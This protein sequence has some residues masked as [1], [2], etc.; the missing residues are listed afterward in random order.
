[1]ITDMTRSAQSLLRPCLAATLL[2]VGLASLDAQA[3]L[4][5]QDRES[6]SSSKPELILQKGH[7]G[8]INSMA[9]SPDGKFIVTAGNDSAVKIWDASTGLEL[10]SLPGN[11]KQA[12]AVAF[13]SDGKLVATG[14]EDWKLRVWEFET[15]RQ[16]R[17]IDVGTAITALAFSADGRWLVTGDIDGALKLCDVE[18]DYAS[19]DL[20]GY[21]NHDH[22]FSGR[23]T[24]TTFSPDSRF[25]AAVGSDKTA[26][27]WD[28]ASGKL[29]HTFTGANDSVDGISFSRE[30]RRLAFGSGNEKIQIWNIHER[31]QLIKEID[32]DEG[33]VS[34]VVF[35]P[36]GKFLVSTGIYGHVWDA[37]D[38]HQVRIFEAD[39]LSCLA[40][41][42][43]GRLFATANLH[44]PRVWDTDT[45]LEF[46]SPKVHA[47]QVD[48]IAQTFDGKWIAIQ[49]YHQ[50]LLWN[51]S[52]NRDF[53][54]RFFGFSPSFDLNGSSL[55]FAMYSST[56]PGL[57]I[58]DMQKQKTL[59]RI[60][61]P[62]PVAVT[63]SPDGSSIAYLNEG[64]SLQIL[65][66]V[67]GKQRLTLKGPGAF[68]LPAFSP[69]GQWVAYNEEND[70]VAVKN[71]NSGQ[72]FVLRRD[73]ETTN[74]PHFAFS[75]DGRLLAFPT[76]HGVGFWDFAVSGAFR[77]VPHPEIMG[78]SAIRFSPDGK[79]VAISRYND[80]NVGTIDILNVEAGKEISAL[81]YSST[82][83]ADVLFTP[84]ES[85]LLTA[86]YDGVVR[87]WD[88]HSGKMQA[89]L[90]IL[91][92]PSNRDE[93]DIADWAVVDADGRFDGSPGGLAAF[94]WVVGDETL[95]LDQLKDRYYEPGLLTKILGFNK[96]P[97]RDVAAFK[98][99]RLF[100]DVRFRAP[101]PGSMQL[102]LTLKNRGGGIGPV[103]VLVNGK[104]AATDARG[105]SVN[106]N[107]SEANLTVDLSG[108]DY[109]PGQ[110]NE[111]RVVARNQEGYLASRGFT[112]TW[113][114]EGTRNDSPPELWAIVGGI[115]TYASPDVKLRYAAKDAADMAHALRLAGQK[116]FGVDKVHLMLLTTENSPGALPPVKENFEKAFEEARHA[117]PQDVLLVYLAGHGVALNSPALPG[118]S[119]SG[120]TDLYA[121]L[122]ADARSANLSDL[123]DPALRAQ[124]TITSDELTD[125]IK[126]IPALKQVMILDT[127]DAGAAATKLV[128][129]RD[130]PADQVRALDRLKDRTGFHVLM[131]AAADKPSYEASE[132][133]QGLLT[134]ALLLGMRG[135]SLRNGEFMDVSQ[136]FQ[137]ATDE[138]PEL[139]KNI[140]GIQKPIVAAPSG[141]SFDVGEV[142]DSVKASIHL[143][144]AKPFLLRPLLLD[145]DQLDDELRLSAALRKRLDDESYAVAGG[146]D[147]PL[148]AVFLDTDEFPGAIRVNGSYRVQGSAVAITVALRRDDQKF[149]QLQVQGTKENI[150]DMIERLVNQIEGA[151]S[152][153]PSTPR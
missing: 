125:W 48:K 7:S 21:L 145:A 51:W 23:V 44:H 114:P 13:S 153:L 131:G 45:M 99:V 47:S 80:E 33:A 98:D 43:D 103:Q 26:R 135:A 82:S 93:L 96:E 139:S 90:A 132:Y 10:R 67:T 81:Q 148:S 31:Y 88:L 133:D 122:T 141:T 4:K 150:P 79:L 60:S 64:P 58:W 3:P 66:A 115:S 138:V 116:L 5:D 35:S 22:A 63:L 102:K 106:P 97:V 8:V 130:I 83:A 118:A 84:D 36:D 109:V 136:W 87:I 120:A 117:K 40:F 100:P 101:T 59:R 85:H 65:D 92:T 142:D 107:A 73:G 20:E 19:R 25:V 78:D 119:L 105:S 89:T 126:Q 62:T 72:E 70:A 71:V 76:V 14:G 55:A 94:H 39:P 42:R 147:A 121:Y 18:G 140:G 144:S 54:R 12:Y 29:R 128:E 34:A 110:A 75:P 61:S 32:Q 91:A 143:A 57:L 24:A 108:S 11:A 30:G 112:A 53:K 68:N 6:E 134:Y 127:C 151:V 77:I 28:V 9:L 27:L 15:G 149:S 95:D 129:R 152:Q 2:V 38:F 86:D 1:M 146:T 137:Y 37:V 74:S 124:W 50:L 56:N 41:S 52:A 46:P 17:S 49:A 69:D 104:E 16:I 113:T 111:I 123:S